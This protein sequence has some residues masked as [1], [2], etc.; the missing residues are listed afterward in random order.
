MSV[1]WYYSLRSHQFAAVPIFFWSEECE[2]ITRFPHQARMGP[3]ATHKVITALLG[4]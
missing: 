4:I 1:R 2:V 3:G